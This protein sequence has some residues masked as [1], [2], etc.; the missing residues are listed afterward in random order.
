MI[1][2]VT[3]VAQEQVYEK[4]DLV[5]LANKYEL[6]DGKVQSKLIGAKIHL[7]DDSTPTVEDYNCDYKTRTIVVKFVGITTA[8]SFS[9]GTKFI[10]TLKD[11]TH[12]VIKKKKH[13]NHKR[14][15]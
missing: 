4:L 2:S 9:F 14:N 5:D 10:V 7:A 1:V 11:D 6:V 15:N 13:N 8:S 3:M 12:K